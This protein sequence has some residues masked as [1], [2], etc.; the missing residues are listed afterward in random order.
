M[1]THSM[2]KQSGPC[3]CDLDTVPYSLYGLNILTKN[4]R[5]DAHLQIRLTCVRFLGEALLSV[6]SLGIGHW[7]IGPVLL[8]VAVAVLHGGFVLPVLLDVAH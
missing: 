3:I 2:S 5:L 1:Q 6:W 8:G 7:P 4:P